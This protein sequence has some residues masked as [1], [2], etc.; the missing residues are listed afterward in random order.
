MT[1]AYT[2][3]MSEMAETTKPITSDDLPDDITVVGRIPRSDGQEWL[4][5]IVTFRGKDYAT[6]RVHYKDDDG[7][8]RPSKHGIN[9]HEELLPEIIKGLQAADDLLTERAT[10]GS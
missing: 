4:I 8:L 6:A 5:G 10:G 9:V 2:F 7:K 1:D 3:E